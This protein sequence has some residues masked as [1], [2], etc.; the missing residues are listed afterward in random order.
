MTSNACADNQIQTLYYGPRHRMAFRIGTYLALIRMMGIG[1]LVT[2]LYGHSHLVDQTHLRLSRTRQTLRALI[3]EGF[4]SEAGQSAVQRLRD[5]HRGLAD[6]T[7]D[8]YRYV[9]AT[10][11]LEPVRWNGAFGRHALNASELG[12]L[13]AFWHRVGEAMGIGGLP[14]RLADWQA[15]QRAYEA[16]HLRPTPEGHHLAQLCLRDVVKLTVPAGTRWAFRGLMRSTMEPDV[17]DILGI[18]PAR[19]APHWAVRLGLKVMT[20]ASA[21]PRQVPGAS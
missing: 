15:L 11:F 20:S 3:C 16:Q 21:R 18:A 8:D 14:N 10:F 2:A 6:T 13:L 7:G 9:L 12:T 4:E 5:A 19:G 17:R 1:H